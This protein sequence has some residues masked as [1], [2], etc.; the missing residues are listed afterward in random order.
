MKYL[1]QMEIDHYLRIVIKKDQFTIHT[2]ILLIMS[3]I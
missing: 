2:C 3:D 1:G